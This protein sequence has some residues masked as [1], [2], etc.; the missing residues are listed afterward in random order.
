MIHVEARSISITSILESAVKELPTVSETSKNIIEAANKQLESQNVDRKE[1]PHSSLP[2]NIYTLKSSV[3]NLIAAREKLQTAKGI[4][5]SAE[6]TKVRDRILNVLATAL[7]LGIVAAAILGGLAL[8]GGSALAVAAVIASPLLYLIL[9]GI[10]DWFFSLDRNGVA[11][12]V[13]GN[14]ASP[15]VSLFTGPALPIYNAI[16]KVSYLKSKFEEEAHRVSLQVKSIED[17]IKNGISYISKEPNP[18]L[19]LQ[20]NIKKYINEAQGK[21]NG[22]INEGNS[23]QATNDEIQKMQTASLGDIQN[24]QKAIRELRRLNSYLTEFKDKHLGL[25]IAPTPA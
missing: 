25:L 14:Y 9:C 16:K 21:L 24:H 13:P 6:K 23:P 7:L 19:R 2:T 17:D 22:Q 3:E 18:V 4:Y 15:I 8:S 10:S 1:N 20:E 12:R 5:E 11:Y